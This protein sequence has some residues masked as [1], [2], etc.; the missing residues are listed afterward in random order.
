[1]SKSKHSIEQQYG[2]VNCDVVLW[3]VVCNAAF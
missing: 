2:V 3:D 1:M